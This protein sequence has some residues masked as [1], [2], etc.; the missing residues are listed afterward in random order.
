MKTSEQQQR[1]TDWMDGEA[2]GCTVG[3]EV[4]V[5]VLTR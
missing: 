4:V 1:Q 5:E 2:P 3:M